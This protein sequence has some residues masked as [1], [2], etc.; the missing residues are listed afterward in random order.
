MPTIIRTCEYDMADIHNSSMQFK[1][2]EDQKISCEVFKTK[3]RYCVGICQRFYKINRGMS[4]I[5]ELF[6]LG[7]R[8]SSQNTCYGI[9]VFS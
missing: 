4:M 2:L 6:A 3:Q 8:S 1:Y 5:I 7:A 9:A